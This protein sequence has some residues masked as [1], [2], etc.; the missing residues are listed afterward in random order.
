MR[1]PVERTWSQLRHD[2]PR[3]R[4]VAPENATRN[5]ILEF[6]DSPRVRRR[7]DYAT[8]LENWLRHYDREQ[9]FLTFLEDVA[10]DP[11]GVLGAL[12]GFLGVDPGLPLADDLAVPVH[13][14]R[15]TPLPDWARDHL[16]QA[17]R[18]PDKRLEQ[19]LGRPLPWPHTSD[20]IHSD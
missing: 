2:F 20:V 5:Q 3:W 19:L 8:C 4:G 6:F 18:E 10:R 9:F 12:F 16:R 15:D 7:G 14:A 13:P 11:S 1:D 17:F